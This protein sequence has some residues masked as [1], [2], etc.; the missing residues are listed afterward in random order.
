[1]AAYCG[2]AALLMALALIGHWTP[3]QA[4]D[5]VPRRLPDGSETCDQ[6]SQAPPA[7]P[8]SMPDPRPSATPVLPGQAPGATM[9]HRCQTSVGWCQ[10]VDRPA[11]PGTA[12][13]CGG[14]PGTT[15]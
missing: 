2:L 5:C 4:Q 12:C 15:F 3:A 10:F 7:P 13:Q 1:M 11:P 8:A 6:P 14:R 9:A